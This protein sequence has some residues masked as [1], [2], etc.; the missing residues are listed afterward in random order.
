MADGEGHQVIDFDGEVVI[1][2]GSIFDE[3]FRVCEQLEIS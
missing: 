3:V 1:V 2:P